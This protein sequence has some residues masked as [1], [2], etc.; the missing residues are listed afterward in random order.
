MEGKDNIIDAI[1]GFNKEDLDFFFNTL[2][3]F[4]LVDGEL[5]LEEANLIGEIASEVIEGLDTREKLHK[6]FTEQIKKS[7]N[8]N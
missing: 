3:S 1:K 2:I 4:A 7:S 6:W 5:A 8:K